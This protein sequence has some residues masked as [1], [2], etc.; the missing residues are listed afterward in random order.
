MILREEL[1][2]ELKSFDTYREQLYWVGV[3]AGILKDT[4][5][6]RDPEK[7]NHYNDLM[8]WEW[9]LLDCVGYVRTCFE[10]LMEYNDALDAREVD[11]DQELDFER[12]AMQ[13]E[14]DKLM[15]SIRA[16]QAE[17]DRSPAARMA[18]M[19]SLMHKLAIE[20]TNM[21]S[22][23]AAFAVELG[24]LEERQTAVA[25]TE[26]NWD[27]KYKSERQQLKKQREDIAGQ[28]ATTEKMRETYDL[29]LIEVKGRERQ[30]S[31]KERQVGIT[32]SGVEF[33][34]QSESRSL[35]I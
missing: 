4:P 3:G 7:P 29:L 2:G 26:W 10:S 14:Q 25:E 35:E 13:A 16:R 17:L 21:E 15:K 30:V 33:G 24:E 1:E 34:G 8:L 27:E 32:K 18:E 22:Q 12:E 28:R 19:Q 23:R 20:Q 5:P 11:L 6:P 9:E 31:E